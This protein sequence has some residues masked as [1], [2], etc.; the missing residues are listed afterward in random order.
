MAVKLSYEEYL[1]ELKRNAVSIPQKPVKVYSQNQIRTTP[2]TST[3][4]ITKGLV[5]GIAGGVMRIAPLTPKAPAVQKPI[6]VPAINQNPFKNPLE[7]TLGTTTNASG[8]IIPKYT[9][10]GKPISAPKL[11]PFSPKTELPRIA[12]TQPNPVAKNWLAKNTMAGIGGFNKGLAQTADFI[13]PNVITPKP[14]QKTLDY[15]KNLGSNQQEQA[16]QINK[17]T[18]TE[19]LGNLYQGTIAALPN[20]A[21]AIMSGGTSAAPQIGQTAV[22][23]GS[24]IGTIGTSLKSLAKNP[25]F[26][27]SFAQTTGST[28]EQA[29]QEGANEAQAQATAI[30]S[31]LLNAGVEVG[32]GIEAFNPANTGVKQWVKSMF[33]EG[34]EEVV[35]SV[36]ENLTKKALYAQNTPYVST[37]QNAVLN[38]I[39]AGQQ[40]LGG[41]V[42]GGILG[43]GQTL[44][45]KQ[46][47]P[48]PSLPTIQKPQ[49]PQSMR[50]VAPPIPA[51]TP[52][53]PAVMPQAPA[54][55]APQLIP[56]A[57][58]IAPQAVPATTPQ[59]ILRT[60]ETAKL[61][62]AQR[63]TSIEAPTFGKNTVGSAESAFPHVQK[64]SKFRS[65]TIEKSP[66]FTQVEKELLNPSD[67]QY[68]V[69]GEKQSIA[70]A[71]QRLEV[72]FAGEVADIPNKSS[73]NG[74]DNDTA[75][76]ILEK[77][78]NDAKGT[79]ENSPEWE[80][81]KRWSKM[82]QS[83]NTDAGQ[84]IQANSKYSRTPE[85]AVVKGQ[86]VVDSV[87]REIKKTNPRKVKAVDN[88]TK[89]VVEVIQE[90]EAEA[91]QEAAKEIVNTVENAN[92]NPATPKQ[93]KIL[94]PAEMLAKKI[95]SSTKQNTPKSPDAVTDMVNELF[96]SAKESPLP[97]KVAAAQRSP[98]EYLTQAIQNKAEYTDVWNQAKDVLTVKYADNP[99]VLN[100]LDDYFNKGILPTY[101]QS[102]LTKSVKKSISELGIDL[103]KIITQS[104][105]DKAAALQSITDYLTNETGA[106]GDSATQLANDVYKKYTKI[107]K[108]KADA[109]LKSMFREVTPKGQK[110]TYQKVMELINMGA[111]DRDNIRDIIKQKNGIPVLE[112]S[113][114]SNIISLMEQAQNLQDGS[115]D[116]RLLEARVGQIIANK[117]PPTFKEKF[118]SGLMDSMLGN[119][120][121][122]ISRNAGGNLMFAI[123]ETIKEVPA[124]IIDKAV[125]LKTGERTRTLPSAAKAAAYGAGLKKGFTE[126]LADYKNKV[127]TAPS[128]IANDID[129]NR[130]VFQK[131][132]A[133]E[134]DR[135]VKTGLSM[136]DRPFYEAS[137]AKR[138]AELEK[139]RDMGKLGKEF[140]NGDFA[141]IA[142][143]IAKVDALEATFQN[144]GLIVSGFNEIKKGLG[145]ISK[146]SIGVDVLGQTAMPFV[147][148]PANI[149]ERS[150]EYSPIGIAKNVIKTGQEAAAGTFDQRRFSD[151]TARNLIGIGLASLATSLL[152]KGIITG[153]LDKDKDARAAQY[154]TGMQPY[155]VKFGDHYYSYDWVPVVGPAVAAGADYAQAAGEEKDP[156]SK[157]AAGA[158]AAIKTSTGMSA[159]QGTQRLMGSYDL[160]S[161]LFDTVAGGTGQFVP[162]LVRQTAGVGDQYMRETYDPNPLKKQ[163]KTLMNSVPGLRQTLPIKIDT[164]GK[165][166]LQNQGRGIASKAFDNYINPGKFTN[167]KGSKIS[168]ELMRLYK[169]NGYKTQFL[170]TAPK[171]FDYVTGSGQNKKSET[172]NLSSDEFV[173]Y[174]KQLGEK[175]TNLM[176]GVLNS[177]WYK[178]ASDYQKTQALTKINAYSNALAKRDL[179]KA[180]N[181][182]YQ[183]DS[184]F[185]KIEQ[186]E[187]N[188]V[189][190]S[191]YYSIKQ[192]ADL[193]GNG[194]VSKDELITTLNGSDLPITQKAYL[195]KL[196]SKAKENPYE[197]IQ[198]K[199]ISESTYSK[200][201]ELLKDVESTKRPNGKTISGSLERNRRNKLMDAGATL[202]EAN[203]YIKAMYGD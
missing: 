192:N 11:G 134:L 142:D 10:L 20:A 140:D 191:K 19:T 202:Q 193:N 122:L 169:D 173:S 183:L 30:I 17:E 49:I 115:Y 105:G 148:T 198:E 154:Q 189:D 42:A 53:T 60:A 26:W 167:L 107:L 138:M 120:R 6:P 110:S 143:T 67:Y 24:L 144:K 123:P 64:V 80:R 179:L 91:A 41:A 159:M 111:Y 171:N 43:G 94:S 14:V 178:N 34:K 73:L 151:E 45:S 156:A 77:Y 203:A 162:S 172:I 150:L 32:G 47:R 145:H 170:Q 2:S 158:K 13:L 9:P 177:D 92:T 87:E 69:I 12:N 3:T 97:E 187:K 70:E 103:N 163:G 48:A 58:E 182:P 83:K 44:L 188:G 82:M 63:P 197:T 36:V 114:V 21:M 90:T 161:G 139:I 89:A 185:S 126:Q 15:Y 50:Q 152:K 108:Q 101:S 52:H 112:N 55:I 125:S 72:D 22:K 8:R 166:I 124:A 23:A 141:Q 194:S 18:G 96:R 106:T 149:F 190:F 157:M 28:Y 121:T 109:K 147:K 199:G 118:I 200:Y 184:E 180:R 66:M 39:E 65:N 78:K 25:M 40:F 176:T 27:N 127:S 146:A 175:A 113:D 131:D 137:Y 86:Q 174:Q 35:Q 54:S 81:V 195:F 7:K 132:F 37:T 186:A 196:Q 51:T 136:G 85:G 76:G 16:A 84:F 119:F 79:P 4:N 29:K 117:I 153:S 1:D 104:R 201:Y 130:R 155:S 62:A 98:I 61:T 88:E 68:D 135:L 57:A 133:N 33:D 59:P 100:M 128:G 75:Y 129:M 116:R 95:E 31:G 5:G 46:F 74:A 99:D 38:P 102:T 71:K 56:R 168:D 181:L 164:D 160:A 93:K 165:P